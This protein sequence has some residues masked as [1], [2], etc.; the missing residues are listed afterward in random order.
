MLPVLLSCL[1]TQTAASWGDQSSYYQMCVQH[2]S[3]QTCSSQPSLSAWSEARSVPERLL[4]ITC[5]EDCRYSCMWETVDEMEKRHG[6]VPQFHGKWPFHRVL[7]LQEPASVLF[8]VLNLLSN[9]GM[10]IWFMG[11]VPSNCSMYRCWLFYSFT[12]I[13]AW[14]W[15]T[16][17]HARD[18]DLTEMLDYFSAFATVLAS[19]LVC[20]I[21][22][23]GTDNM[24]AVIISALCVAFFSHH[25]FNMAFVRFD[26]GH[27]MKVNVSVGVLNGLGWLGWAYTHYQDGPHVRKGV[28]TIII[29]SLSV[30]LE[31]VEF[32]PWWWM[33]D[34]HALWHL[35]TFPLPLLWYRFAAGDCLKLARDGGLLTE[36]KLL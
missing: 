3:R 21:R 13:N 20:C 6:L 22:I 10:V 14:V 25:V 17:F 4:G 12:A 15:S 31:L 2:C 36:K 7:G 35:A 28:L 1:V 11:T 23:V 8:S 33:V 19:L 27:N 30:L 34:S 9:L 24:K 29:L 32:S 18:T 16:V 5:L 26:Y